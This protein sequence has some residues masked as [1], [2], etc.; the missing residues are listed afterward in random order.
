MAFLY[1]EKTNTGQ[2]PTAINAPQMAA[3]QNGRSALLGN[4][5]TPI[6][7]VS[8]PDYAPTPTGYPAIR[9]LRAQQ[10]LSVPG[11]IDLSKRQIIDN[12]PDP[13]DYGS[14]YSSRSQL[15]DGRWISY[16]TIY[17]GKVHTPAEG[18]KNAVSTGKHLGV[19]RAD[20]PSDVL[21][22]AENALHSRGISVNGRTLN[23]DLWAA[24]KQGKQ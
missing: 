7:G 18:L 21:D 2:G 12:G 4:S 11:N 5:S 20:T 17:D 22:E 3:P 6:Q 1:G 8:S 16:P 14:E 24:M 15:P 10:Y 19:Y 23:G 9:N 13:H